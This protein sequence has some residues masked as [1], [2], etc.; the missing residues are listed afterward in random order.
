MVF[1]T[2]SFALELCSAIPFMMKQ[3][4]YRFHVADTLSQMAGG[5]SILQRFFAEGNRGGHS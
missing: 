4:G 1:G 5:H 3:L 2:P